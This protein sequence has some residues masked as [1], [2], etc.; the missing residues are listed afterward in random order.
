MPTTADGASRRLQAPSHHADRTRDP[1]TVTAVTR[2]TSAAA[3]GAAASFDAASR[4]AQRLRPEA[5]S[6]PPWERGPLDD[7]AARRPWNTRV[8]LER[9]RSARGLARRR[10]GVTVVIVNWNTVEVT[11]DVVRAVRAYSPPDVRILVIDNASTDGSRQRFRSWSSVDTMLLRRNVGHGIALDLGV[12]AC[13]T[14]VVV[15]LDSDAIPLRPGWLD[16]AVQPVRSG[17]AVAAGLRSS[18]DFVHPVYSAVDAATFV[19]RRL[20][21]QV[22]IEPGVTAETV[23][24]GENAWDTGELMTRRLGADEV[25]FVDPTENPVDGLPG[26]TAGGVVY[27][28]GGISRSRDSVTRDRAV[29]QWRSACERLGLSDA[30]A[31]GETT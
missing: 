23:R 17:A 2:V 25:A 11:G 1:T 6:L 14:S 7:L 3:T 26:M 27:H 9:W 28:H 30:L 13:T 18:R 5:A 21:Y 16:P 12:L 8:T 20:S 15:T 24:W 31:V 29:T 22:H 10:P 4:V 19:R